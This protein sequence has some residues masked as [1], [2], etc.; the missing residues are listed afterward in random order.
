MFLQGKGCS[1]CNV[2]MLNVRHKGAKILQRFAGQFQRIRIVLAHSGAHFFVR[3]KFKL[4]TRVRCSSI[5]GL[6]SRT[7]LF[8]IPSCSYIYRLGPHN[9]ALSC[10]RETQAHVQVAWKV[11][12]LFQNKGK[13][14]QN[15]PVSQ[16]MKRVFQLLCMQI[17]VS[18]AG[19]RIP[20]PTNWRK[21]DLNRPSKDNDA[22][23]K[24]VPIQ[25]QAVCFWQCNSYQV[26][27]KCGS[28]FPDLIWKL[29]WRNFCLE[30]STLIQ[31]K[32]KKLGSEF[33]FSGLQI[34]CQWM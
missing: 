32:D 18:S 30:S 11:W 16:D 12:L 25:F 31:D 26:F 5:L 23:D 4:S 27:T 34:S 7:A 1:F 33:L 10:I 3:R 29:Q 6:F 21:T 8:P 15:A 14:C 24:E 22:N 17:T 13:C 20:A 28:H 9:A 19:C 2:F